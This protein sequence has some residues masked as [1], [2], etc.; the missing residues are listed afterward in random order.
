MTTSSAK[1]HRSRPA[2]RSAPLVGR[3]FRALLTLLLA[4]A[5]LLSMSPARATDDAAR[6]RPVADAWTR[7]WATAPTLPFSEGISAT[8]FADRTIRQVLHLGTGGPELRLTL[9]NRFGDRPL[10]VDATEVAR[11]GG[12]GGIVPRTATPVTFDGAGSVTIPAGAEATSDP[13]DFA[14]RA[15]TDVTVSLYLA[16]PTG[17]TTWHRLAS[18]T[19]WVSE[20]GDHTGD[21]TAAAFPTTVE[22]F[23]FVTGVDVSAPADA[24]GTVVTLGASHTDGV[25]STVDANRRYPDVLATRLGG[26]VGVPNLGIGANQVINDTEYG[27]IGAVNRFDQDVLGQP[28]VTD[29]IWIQGLNDILGAYYLPDDAPTTDEIIAG[30]EDVI[31]RA[32]EADL[33]II[34][35][36]LGPIRGVEEWSPEGEAKRQ[37]LNRWIR[38]ESGFDGILDV[39]A[40]WRDPADHQRLNPVYDS[41][42]HLHPNDLGYRVLAEAIDLDC[43]SVTDPAAVPTGPRA[44]CTL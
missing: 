32:H 7:A 30:Y 13:V 25:G 24:T 34:G 17:P 29:V 27:S 43:L 14:T 8:G 39:D 36:T 20:P 31:A 10:T 38:E 23:F 33:R 42:D 40:L 15:G 1:A 28:G 9:S 44:D 35:G 5:A 12:R 41:G 21:R 2:H 4:M 3:P 18:A 26:E 16:E 37:V 22:H 11:P 6:G 19:T